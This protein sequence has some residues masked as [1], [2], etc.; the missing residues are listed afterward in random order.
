MLETL[1]RALH[2]LMPFIT[3]EIWQR[4]APLAGKLGTSIMH[5]PYPRADHSRADIASIE[6]MQWVMAVIT[7]VR[8]IRAER[9]SPG[10]AAAGAVRRGHGSRRE[11]THRNEHYLKGLAR[12]ESLICLEAGTQPPES[13]MGLVA[14]LKVLVRSAASSTSR[15]SWRASR[16]KSTASR[17]NSPRRAASWPMPTSSRVRRPRWSSRKRAGWPNSR[18]RSQARPAAR[19]GRRA[20]G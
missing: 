9:D 8:T 19:P 16:R 6:E 13:A 18:R 20:A 15:K 7:A 5:E 14:G 17:R 3:E 1:L 11:W 10:Q 2:P 4:V 12:M